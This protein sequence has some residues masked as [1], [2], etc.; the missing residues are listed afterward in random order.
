MLGRTAAKSDTPE[1]RAM[2]EAVAAYASEWIG[3]VYGDDGSIKD[4]IQVIHTPAGSSLPQMTIAEYMDRMIATLVRGGDLS[5]ISRDNS[6]GSNPQQQDADALLEDDCALVSETLQ[7]QLDRLVIRM[8]HGD[9]TPAAYIVIEPPSTTDQSKELAIDT[10]LADLGVKQ[11]PA[12]L[13]E[14]YGREVLSTKPEILNTPAAA[15]MVA[16]NEATRPAFMDALS[17]DLKPLGAA[18]EGAM[19]AGD[20]S[21]MRAALKKIS[22]QMPDFMETTGMEA[23]LTETLTSALTD[24][25]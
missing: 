12:D 9:E 1:G 22:A 6:T 3:V 8:V 24:P 23:Y 21:A 14:R 10:G 7:T 5:T 4:P 16:E 20:E 18:L 15:P 13:A 11:D 17:A 25:Q 19:N 2:A